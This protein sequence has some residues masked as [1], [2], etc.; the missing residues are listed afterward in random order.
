MLI[1]S[2]SPPVQE[3]MMTLS[4]KDIDYYRS[5]LV[6]HRNQSPRHHCLIC[7][8]RRCETWVRAYD[9]LAKAGLLM[10]DERARL[11]AEAE[12]GT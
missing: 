3:E 11:A 4:K 12:A 8:V 7:L 2:P 10:A 5:V 1:P 9:A 6:N